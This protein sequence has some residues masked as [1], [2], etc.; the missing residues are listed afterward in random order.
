MDSRRTFLRIAATGAAVA[1]AGCNDVGDN[2]PN[3]EGVKEGQVLL[4]NSS[5]FPRQATV[6]AFSGNPS[7]VTETPGE[8]VI[9]YNTLTATVDPDS[10]K[11]YASFISDS[12]TFTVTAI[13]DE[14]KLESIPFEYPSEEY[15][16][17]HFMV[18]GDAVLNRVSI[19]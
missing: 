18:G 16:E 4:R 15:I 13:A 5:D 14:R 1:V 3:G 6:Y 9:P 11:S 7:T 17:V 19:V 2:T 12:G 8:E 10:S